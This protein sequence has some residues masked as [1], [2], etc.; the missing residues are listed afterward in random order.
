MNNGD[1]FSTVK[2][3]GELTA[4]RGINA[5][6]QEKPFNHVVLYAPIGDSLYYTSSNALPGDDDWFISDKFLTSS[7]NVHIT[8]NLFVSNKY[9]ESSEN[10]SYD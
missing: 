7:R 10:S 9:E 6:L 8:G 3:T 5:V 2:L 4:S 1:A